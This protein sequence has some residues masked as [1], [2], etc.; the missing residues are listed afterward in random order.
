MMFYDGYH[1]G[2]MHLLWWFIWAMLLFWIFATPFNIPGQRYR[3]RS[4]LD[5]L[6][7][8]LASGQIST[9]QYKE[10]KQLLDND[11]AN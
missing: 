3:R 4:P 11:S 8:R 6:H 1:F 2:G 10:Q 9:E 7:D 5:I